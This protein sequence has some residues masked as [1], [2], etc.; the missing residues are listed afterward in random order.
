VPAV[1]FSQCNN[2]VQLHIHEDVTNAN[3]GFGL[4]DPCV[5][6]EGYPGFIGGQNRVRWGLP[7]GRVWG[8]FRFAGERL[9]GT[10]DLGE[11]VLVSI[12]FASY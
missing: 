2:L 4:V 10:D 6:L 5:A 1:D 12:I 11:P 9:I 3:Q 8:L 7:S